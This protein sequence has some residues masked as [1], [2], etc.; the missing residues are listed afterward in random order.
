MQSSARFLGILITAAV[1]LSG[2][3]NF[4]NLSEGGA[5]MAQVPIT[6]NPSGQTYPGKFI[7]HDLLTPDPLL[8]GKFYE[9]LF[10][11][12]IEYQGHYAVARHGGKLVAGILKVEPSDDRPGNGVW[13]PSVSAADVDAAAGLIDRPRYLRKDRGVAWGVLSEPREAVVVAVAVASQVWPGS[14]I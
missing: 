14:S 8:A 4:G 11:W 6:E 1:F 12:Q 2:C 3:A 7:W 5:E 10:G 9:E 13:I